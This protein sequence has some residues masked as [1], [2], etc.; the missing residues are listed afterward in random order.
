MAFAIL[1]APPRPARRPVAA[2]PAAEV[3][4]D[5]TYA[6]AARTRLARAFI[7]AIE[8]AT[9]RPGLIRRAAGY[10]DEVGQ[11]RDFWRVM[12]DRFGLRLDILSGSLD[13]MPRQ[14]PLVVVANHPYGILDGLVMGHILSGTRSGEFRILAHQVFGR[15]EA[16]RRVILPIDFAGSRAAVETNLATRAAAIRYL[17]AGGAV[18][19]FPGGTVSTASHP[20]GRPMDP[21]WRAFTARMIRK[22]GATVVP[23]WFDGANSRLFQVASHLHM[24]LRMALLMREFRRRVDRPVRLAIGA[25]IGPAELAHLSDGKE[26]MDFLR[27]R[28]YGL[29]PEPLDPAALGHEFEAHHRR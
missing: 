16:L 10:A 9:G 15:A 11:G 28:T 13:L 6:H 3:A 29:S 12:V 24:T 4:R 5:I 14:G 20:F 25:P 22:S 7:R 26:M 1:D 21:A 18:G 17:R 2:P 19:V 27:R 8:N 23:I